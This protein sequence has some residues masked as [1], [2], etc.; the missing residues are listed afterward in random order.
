M[1]KTPDYDSLKFFMAVRGGFVCG[2]F[3]NEVSVVEC[4]PALFSTARF[5]KWNAT[6]FFR[7]LKERGWA[8]S[9]VRPPDTVE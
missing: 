1:K 8:V 5:V 3:V 9:D 6:A 7:V 4:A 2:F